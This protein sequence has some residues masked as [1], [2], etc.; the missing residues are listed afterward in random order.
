MALILTEERLKD[1]NEGGCQQ[2]DDPDDGKVS[3]D[4]VDAEDVAQKKRRK[5]TAMVV[6]MTTMQGK[7]ISKLGRIIIKLMMTT[8]AVALP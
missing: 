5:G 7:M 2:N 6:M 8:V 1:I 4:H 3:D